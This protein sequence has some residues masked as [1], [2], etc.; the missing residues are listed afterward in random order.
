MKEL[1]NRKYCR[2]YCAERFTYILGNVS[3]C[4]YL[5]GKNLYGGYLQ[6]YTFYFKISV[7]ID[8]FLRFMPCGTCLNVTSSGEKCEILTQNDDGNRV[9]AFGRIF[10]EATQGSL[11][12]LN[13]ALGSFIVKVCLMGMA[14]SYI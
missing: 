1:S 8:I 9:V 7:L 4:P 6:F 3:M 12:N 11:Q 5:E 13:V 2:K 10:S 14:S